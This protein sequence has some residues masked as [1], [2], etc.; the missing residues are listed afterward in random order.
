MKGIPI[1]DREEDFTADPAE[2]FFDL[3]FVFAF[4]RLV[5]HLN[6]HPTWTGVGEF[7]LLFAMIWLPWSQ[8]TW[9]ANAVAGNTRP[10]RALVMVATVA[11]IPMA[12][13]VTSAFGD[14]GPIF[15]LM[16]SVIVVIALGTMI[17]GLAGD[18]VVLTSS[19][20]YAIPTGIAIVLMVI[21]GF[22]ERDVRI[23]LWLGAVG[24]FVAGT[25]RAGRSEW[26]V[27]P[28]H[29]A[30]RHGLILIVALGEIIVAVGL[31]VVEI[32]DDGESP[33]ALTVAALVAAGVLAVL[34]W[35][36]YFDRPLPAFERRHDE[37]DGAI[38]RG[39]F[40]RIVYTY[41]HLPIIGGVIMAA[42]ALEQI[43]LHPDEPLGEPF[44]WMF[45]AG[46]GLY[47]LSIAGAVQWVFSSTAYERIAATAVVAIVILL[48]ADLD[49]IVLLVAADVILLIAL[50]VEHQR[51][52]VQ[53]RT[54]DVVTV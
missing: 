6:H 1:P 7:A 45:L 43:T 50:V 2:L 23:W 38:E 52:E 17:V 25:V 26:L 40:A 37:M 33:S 31:P 47:L 46:L 16:L 41:F 5:Y 42:A 21:G 3:T 29:F 36:G 15:A 14:G 8:F 30:E 11:S 49:G 24:I 12:G 20:R 10:V 22:L 4:S 53:Y 19:I 35:W 44:R 51:V 18:E 32:L 9:A 27:R 28:G 54:S 48:G 13:S 34:L 39:N